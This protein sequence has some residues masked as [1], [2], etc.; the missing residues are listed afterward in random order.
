MPP[1]KKDTIHISVRLETELYLDIATNEE[2]DT[3][4]DKLTARL[5]KKRE[6]TPTQKISEG[7][8][9]VKKGTTLVQDG[10]KEQIYLEYEQARAKLEME[11]IAKIEALYEKQDMISFKNIF[12]QDFP[13]WKT[14]TT[15]QRNDGIVRMV[16][17]YKGLSKFKNEDPEALRLKIE[18]EI[19]NEPTE[20]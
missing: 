1:A 7:E 2:G 4:T 3:F 6:L 18:K 14:L 20:Y 19:E 5:K 15:Q 16:L 10:K 11:K 12:K 13:N 8:Y 9:L 17:D